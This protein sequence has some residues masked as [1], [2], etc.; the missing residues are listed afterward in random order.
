MRLIWTQCAC[1]FPELFAAA[2]PPATTTRD[3][4]GQRTESTRR[5][6][7]KFITIATVGVDLLRSLLIYSPGIRYEM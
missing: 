1:C 5:E 4:R 3:G 7:A 6:Y 2:A